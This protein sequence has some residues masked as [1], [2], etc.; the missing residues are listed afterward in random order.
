[1][2]LDK[3]TC[4][5]KQTLDN[6]DEW[7]DAIRALRGFYVEFYAQCKKCNRKQKRGTNDATD[8][9]AIVDI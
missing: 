2:T 1:M 3:R 4:L 5:D 9:Q 8:E 7:H 6:S